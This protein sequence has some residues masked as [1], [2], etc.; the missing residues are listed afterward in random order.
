M[1]DLLG[2]LDGAVVVAVAAV[3]VMQVA[4]DE[5]VDVVTVGHGLVAAAG[6]VHVVA[7]VP[8]TVVAR[9]AGPGVGGVDLD[10]ALVRMAL[11]RAMHVAVVQIADVVTVL[12]GGVAAIRAVGV[13]VVVV[14]VAVHELVVGC[15]SVDE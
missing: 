4:V 7:G 8:A 9:G 10:L 6:A 5:V 3:R 2:E 13:V 15:F 11:V 14:L 12:E 1:P